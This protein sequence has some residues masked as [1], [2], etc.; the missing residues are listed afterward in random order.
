MKHELKAEKQKPS[1]H[2]SHDDLPELK[3]AKL[4]KVFNLHVKAKV[5]G[6]HK[7][8]GHLEIHKINDSDFKKKSYTDIVH[9]DMGQAVKGENL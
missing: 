5:A 4:G 6:L 7:D 8:G 9:E 2:L 3:G 1:L